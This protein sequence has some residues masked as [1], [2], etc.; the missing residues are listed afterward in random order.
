MLRHKIVIE[1]WDDISSRRKR[2][3]FRMT[4]PGGIMRDYVRKRNCVIFSCYL[5]GGKFKGNK[6]GWAALSNTNKHNPRQAAMFFVKKGCRGFQVAKKLGHSIINYTNKNVYIFPHDKASIAL[7]DSLLKVK[8]LK[9]NS[10]RES[11]NPPV[12]FNFE[13]EYASSYK[14]T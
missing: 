2:D 12:F 6:A 14:V 7:K 1:N 10:F 13:I 8:G 9:G 5:Y 3:C 11:W 4:L